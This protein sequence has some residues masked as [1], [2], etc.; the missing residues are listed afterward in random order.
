MNCYAH[1]YAGAPKAI[2]PRE[3]SY[4]I[5]IIMKKVIKQQEEDIKN[6]KINNIFAPYILHPVLCFLL[7]GLWHLAI[8]S[9]NEMVTVDRHCKVDINNK[10]VTL[11]GYVALDKDTQPLEYLA[12]S[13][14]TKEYESLFALY[15]KPSNI[16]LALLSIGLEPKGFLQRK[17]KGLIVYF[18]NPKA[19][20][21]RIFVIWKDK[22]KIKKRKVESLIW[23]KAN[24]ASFSELARKK[25]YT[26]MYWLFSGSREIRQ[27]D[28]NTGTF[29]NT[30]IY[31]AD[32]F[33]TIIGLQYDVNSVI[34]LPFYIGN[35][36]ENIEAYVNVRE[37]P[38][39]KTKVTLI[40]KPYKP[41]M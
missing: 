33:G 25:V 12:C 23:N 8:N 22:G 36:W 31:G 27:F 37:A 28:F 20:K 2:N 10:R 9:E 5:E 35:K 29:T 11:K 13:P 16:H 41:N 24:K 32:Q 30:K 6:L 19:P 39:S 14:G 21:L 1:A 15:S 7:F 38:K 3:R 17:R 40:I 4:L 26:K 18:P 34:T